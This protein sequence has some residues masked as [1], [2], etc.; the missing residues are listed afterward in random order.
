M[1]TFLGIWLGWELGWR[2]YHVL[3]GL[4]VALASSLATLI[5]VGPVGGPGL[6]VP[7]AVLVLGVYGFARWLR[8]LFGGG[9][10]ISFKLP[11]LPR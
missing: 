5:A 11:D 8:R 1:Y 4:V 3:A 2:G 6:A 10:K 7:T 9:R